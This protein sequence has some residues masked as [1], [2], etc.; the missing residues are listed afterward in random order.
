MRMRSRPSFLCDAVRGRGFLPKSKN[1]VSFT[2]SKNGEGTG[3]NIANFIDPAHTQKLKIE[4][5]A[6]KYILKLP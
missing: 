2:E 6:K 3:L 1:L 5:R 4:K